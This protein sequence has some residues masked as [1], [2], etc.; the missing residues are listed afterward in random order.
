MK[1][2]IRYSMLAALGLLASASTA[3]ALEGSGAEWGARDPTPCAPLSQQ[4]PPTVDQAI[5]LVRCT[6]EVA[7]AGGELTLME[8]VQLEIGA[9][10]P[11]IDMY[12][13]Y[14]MENADTVT[15]TLPLKGSY[16]WARCITRHDA[17]IYG[18]PDMNCKEADVA[19]AEGL[20][21][22]TSF[23]DWRCRIIGSSGAI[24][25]PTAPPQ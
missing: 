3:M 12:N 18:N 13:R 20:C 10:V 21:W 7:Y 9:P 2:I 15:D 1:D 24:R 4:D 11:F 6:G 16:T 19:A 14:V 8:N 17:G 22:K 25:E 5:G 23:G